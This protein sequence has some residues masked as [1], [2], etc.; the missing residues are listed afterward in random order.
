M[1]RPTASATWRPISS[2]AATGRAASTQPS[3][4][5]R[6]VRPVQR[7]RACACTTPATDPAAASAVVITSGSTPSAS[8]CTTSLVTSQPTWQ[9]NAVTA[10]PATAFICHV[11]WEVTSEV[12]HRLADGVEPEVITTAEAAAGSVAGVVHAHARARWTGRTL[13]VEVEGWVDA[14]LP[15]AAAEEI[16]RQVADAVGRAIP[17]AAALTW[18]PRAAP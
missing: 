10:R 1:A 12:V 6:S 15:V 17:D 2:A 16:G 5:T 8:R 7:A 18:V 13:R 9:M 11:G 14:A 3:T 4:S